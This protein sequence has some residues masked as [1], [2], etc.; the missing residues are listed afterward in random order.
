MNPLS[1]LLAIPPG[2]LALPAIAALAVAFSIWG[3]SETRR[4]E[5]CQLAPIP[6]LVVLTAGTSLG[7]LGLA[8]LIRAAVL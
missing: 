8:F 7:V 1:F 4:R 6:R 5:G 2:W 3:E